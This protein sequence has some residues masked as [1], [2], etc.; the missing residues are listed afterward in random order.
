M[1]TLYNKKTLSPLQ[2]AALFTALLVMMTFLVTSQA[3]AQRLAGIIATV[4]GD[5]I[6]SNDLENR[7]DLALFSSGLPN[8]PEIRSNLRAQMLQTLIEE[9]LKLQEARNN[10]INVSD[11]QVEEQLAQLAARNQISKETFLNKLAENNVPL[12]TLRSQ[13]R[14]DISWAQ[15]VQSRLRRQIVVNDNDVD[16]MLRKAKAR[17][18]KMEYRL[19]E[20]LIDIKTPGQSEEAEKFARQL[21]GQ[22]RQGAPFPALAKQFSASSSAAQNGEV[23]WIMPEDLN[24]DK[25]RT[26][27]S[28]MNKGDLSGPIRTVEGFYILFV[29]DTRTTARIDGKIDD[30][31]ITL[32]KIV[33]PERNYLNALE[34]K[35][36]G[37]FSMQNVID[38]LDNKN[39]STSINDVQLS[40]LQPELRSIIEPLAVGVLSPIIK[41]RG[42]MLARYMLCK[43]VKN[44][45]KG[46]SLSREDITNQLGAEQLDLRQRQ[47]LERLKNEAFIEIRRP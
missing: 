26:A 37:C 14:A 8:K 36:S 13:I 20:I 30:F 22:I 18:G 34:K 47:Y 32:K 28:K 44:Q 4:N 41:D 38:D 33:H 21:M 45:S 23:G 11:E 6:T 35:V 5:A 16:D 27:L 46:P 19:A 1:I 31:L 2:Y 29:I 43:K 12:T 15:F 10:D 39:G 9:R 42:D 24:D 25:L 7:I 17:Q 3:Q 40:D